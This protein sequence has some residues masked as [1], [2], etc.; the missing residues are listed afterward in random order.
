MVL[1]GFFRATASFGFSSQYEIESALEVANMRR[2]FRVQRSDLLVLGTFLLLGGLVLLF[3]IDFFWGVLCFV[4][5]FTCFY[6]ALTRGDKE[7]NRD[8]HRALGDW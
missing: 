8:L 7:K 3:I 6:Q 5:S 2:W 1:I 4:L